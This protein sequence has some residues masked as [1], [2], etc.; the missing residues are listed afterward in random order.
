MRFQPLNK[1][2]GADCC[3]RQSQHAQHS[4]FLKQVQNSNSSISTFL[5]LTMCIQTNTL[6]CNIVIYILSSLFNS[7]SWWHFNTK[8][9][10]L[11]RYYNPLLCSWAQC[12][13]RLDASAQEATLH[14]SPSWLVITIKN[15]SSRSA[16]KSRGHNHQSE[17]PSSWKRTVFQAA[18][19]QI[20]HG[21]PAVC[22]NIQPGNAG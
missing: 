12:M 5:G 14:L 16:I 3:E 10:C 15:V 9:A 13:I 22:S 4:S 11:C 6:Y 17:S 1:V 20:W 2:S 21:S 8:W 19:W 18:V 7:K